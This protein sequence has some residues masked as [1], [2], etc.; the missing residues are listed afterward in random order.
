[1]HSTLLLSVSFPSEFPFRSFWRV[2]LLFTHSRYLALLIY[3]AF[4]YPLDISDGQDG[5]DGQEEREL[6]SDKDETEKTSSEAEAKEK[7][8]P[9]DHDDE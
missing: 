7:D 8:W 9:I 1:M 5:G 2:D 6:A 3:L 4:D